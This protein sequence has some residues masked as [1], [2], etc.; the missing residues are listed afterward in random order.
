M[1]RARVWVAGLVTVLLLGCV[2]SPILWSPDGKWLAYT[3]A[4]RPADRVL[5]P[6]WLFE[7]GGG[8][9]LAGPEWAGGRPRGGI[10][11]RLWAT[12]VDDGTSV[13]LEEGRGPLTSPGWN[14][15]GSALA[16]GRLVPQDDGGAR[17]EIVVQEAPDRRRIL[18]ATS[19]GGLEAEAEGLPALSVCWSPD[20]RHLAVPQFQPPGLAVLRADNGRVLKT[21]GDAFFPSWSPDGSKLAFYCV[22]EPEG[23]YCLD[24]ASFGAPRHLAAIAQPSQPPVWAPDGQSLLA[25]RKGT[26]GLGVLPPSVQVELVRVTVDPPRIET[27]QRLEHEPM[28]GD[29]A[30]LGAWFGMDRDGEHLFYTTSIEGQPSQITWHRLRGH[31]NQN[32]FP[33]LDSSMPLGA[34]A[35]SPT[36]P[37]L[38]LRIGPPDILSPPALCDPVSKELTLIAPDDAAR[39]EWIGTLVAAA[40]SIVRGQI[41]APMAGGRPLERASLLPVPGELT[42]ND[43]AAGRLRY[44][45]RLGRP[46]C[47]RPADAPPAGAA[48]QALLDEARLFFDYLCEDYPAA[49]SA[50]EAVE[51]RTVDPDRKLKLL[52]VRAQIDLG[53]G[54]TERA[55]STIAYLGAVQPRR[56]GRVEMVPDGLVWSP[57]ADPGEG[58]PAFLAEKAESVTRRRPAPAGREAAPPGHRNP[59][60]PEPDLVLDPADVLL[61]PFQVAPIEIGPVPVPPLP[62]R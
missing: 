19:L 40:R 6:G 30:F 10:R 56:V 43:P 25:V 38:A 46:L 33:L 15:D 53:L 21:I 47:D 17:F 2:P 59:D 28:D 36:G 54:E 51:A 32:R 9:G 27:V 42:H 16:F 14:P 58:W 61:P 29:Q 12:R 26:P 4:V 3:M 7:T 41:P 57:E 45:G 49:L 55:R 22:G 62:P 31:F 39:A 24:A 11:Y 60:N 34:L 8:R 5:A 13:L 37:K 44:L 1:Q 50:L 18:Q 52:G 23:L 48:M 20:G 35:V